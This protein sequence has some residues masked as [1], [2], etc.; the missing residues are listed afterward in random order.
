MSVLDSKLRRQLLKAAFATMFAI[1]SA[2][3]FA[4]N[5]EA[6]IR[7]NTYGGAIVN[8]P[9]WVAA[10]GGFCAA[11]GL[12]CE[13]TNIPSAPL[14]LQALAAGSLEVVFSATDVSMQSASRGNPILIFAGHS[15]NNIFTLNVRKDIPLPNKA[16]GY[17]AVM[18]DLRKLK[19]GVTARGAATEI[20]TRALFLG[21][22]IDPDTITYVAAGIPTTS[23]PLLISKQLDAAMMLEPF[24]TLCR[25]QDTCVAAVDLTAGEGPPD[26]AALN[27]GFTTFIATRSFIAKRPSD[28]AAFTRAMS[29]TIAWIQVPANFDK[30]VA[31]AGKHLPLGNIPNPDRVLRELVRVQGAQLGIHVDRKAISAFSNFL[32]KYKLI[33]KPVS[34][35]TFVHPSTP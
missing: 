19:I 18:Q 16:N 27:G 24:N 23:Y 11:E 17:P 10:D 34:V 26:L 25:V 6:P 33:D 9:I 31:I 32:I 20:A 30:V 4:Q 29:K 28:M 15:P 5:T 13:P 22:G 12:R 7:I 1:A 3:A 8:L 21:A 2:T 35:E 14:A